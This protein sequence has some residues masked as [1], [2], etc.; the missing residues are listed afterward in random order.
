MGIFILAAARYFLEYGAGDV[1]VATID[2]A[3]VRVGIGTTSPAYNLHVKGTA[4]MPLYVYYSAATDIAEFSSSLSTHT[5]VRINNTH[6]SG[7]A[8]LAFMSASAIKWVDW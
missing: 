3:N 2:G 6:A 1:N 8:Q 7:D 4:N 5:R